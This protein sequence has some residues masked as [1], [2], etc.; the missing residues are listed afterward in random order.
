ML[1]LNL[2]LDVVGAV[3]K[4]TAARKRIERAGEMFGEEGL[5]EFELGPQLLIMPKQIHE[6]LSGKRQVPPGVNL[7]EALR[8]ATQRGDDVLTL[9]QK[10][11][12]A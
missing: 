12:A 4:P 2:A 10:K 3:V 7:L 5:V 9:N 8:I 11:E 1:L 6:M